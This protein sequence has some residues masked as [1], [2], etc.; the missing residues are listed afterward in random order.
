MSRC[1]VYIGMYGLKNFFVRNLANVNAL[2]EEGAAA[3]TS[4]IG[5]KEE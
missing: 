2:W 5:G 3:G 1:Y 4:V